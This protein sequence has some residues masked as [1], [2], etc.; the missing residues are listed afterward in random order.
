MSRKTVWLLVVLLLLG[1]WLFSNQ[2]EDIPC[3]I[4]S[5]VYGASVQGRP[6]TAWKLGTGKN[7]MVLTF[8]IHGWEDCFPSDGQI[9]TDTAQNL[10]ELLQAKGGDVIEPAW[11]VYIVP[12]VNPD[13]LYSGTS[14]DGFGR[15][16]AQG[17]DLNRSF[18]YRFT[19]ETESRYYNADVPLQAPEALALHEFLLAVRGTEKNLLVDVHGWYQQ[20]LTTTEPDSSLYRC[21]S[22][23]F[24]QCPWGSLENGNGYL[25]AWAGYCGGYEAALLEFP[26]ISSPE[27]FYGSGYGHAFHAA[28]FELLKTEACD[29]SS[30]CNY[31]TIRTHS[32]MWLYPARRRRSY[33]DTDFDCG[34]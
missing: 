2:T 25:S 23:F 32:V 26:H 6:L 4:Q 34:G 28:V 21:L 27:D 8:A 7:T 29:F 22:R 20:I 33:C 30:G 10:L 18:P 11:T 13:G 1:G 14:C 17:L 19:P 3:R 31:D 12:T 5:V 16:N 24:P 15:C 9:L